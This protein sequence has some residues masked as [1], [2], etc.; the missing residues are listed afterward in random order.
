MF[1]KENR[2]QVFFNR[3]FVSR[4]EVVLSNFL[5]KRLFFVCNMLWHNFQAKSLIFLGT[6]NF[7]ILFQRSLGGGLSFRCVLGLQVSISIFDTKSTIFL[8][9]QMIWFATKHKS[10]SYVVPDSTPTNE[11]EFAGEI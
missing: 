1:T 4:A 6:F 10:I 3:D 5:S 2:V 7:Q 9:S 8:G 11:V